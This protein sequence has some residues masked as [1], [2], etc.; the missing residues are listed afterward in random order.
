MKK[1]Y[2]TG[3]NGFIGS[4]VVKRLDGDIVAIPHKLI[5]RTPFTPFDY[6]YYCSSYG[7]MIDQSDDKEIWKANVT[8]V[9]SVIEHVKDFRIR[10]F[11]YLSTSS[12]KLKTQTMYSRSKNAAE[13]ML[14]GF[15]EKYDLPICIIRPFSVTGV[16]EQK[17]H[18]IPVLIDAAFTGKTIDVVSSPVHD[19]IDVEDLVD[20]IVTLSKKGARGVYELGNG[21]SVSNLQVLQ[22]VEQITGKKIKAN[23]VDSMRPYDS[24]D[25][26]STNFK[27][28]NYGWL[29]KKKLS[30]S[31][32]EMVDAY[33]KGRYVAE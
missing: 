32:L 16:G 3:V 5:S 23:Y 31:I 20:G 17:S 10:S 30:Q 28:R 9:E 19:F 1:S 29:P 2:I 24:T 8:D 21:R 13:T 26:V 7:N 4:H 22:L 25:W 12:V 33:R 15:M 11:V 14:F 6:F 18:F 27:A